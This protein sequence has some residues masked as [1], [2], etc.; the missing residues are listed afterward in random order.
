MS[1]SLNEILTKELTEME[2]TCIRESEPPKAFRSLVGL[3]IV[4]LL[5]NYRHNL[6]GPFLGIF[7][8]QFKC[9]FQVTE[10]LISN[11]QSFPR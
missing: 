9:I 2:L 1:D 11:K 8:G 5:R 3:I 4:T 7:T 10:C 6:V